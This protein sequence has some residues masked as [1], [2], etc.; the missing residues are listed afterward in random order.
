VASITVSQT[1]VV[2]VGASASHDNR[3]VLTTGDLSFISST[4]GL[5]N[6][7]DNDLIVQNGNVTNIRTELASGFNAGGGYWNGPAGILSSQAGS[8]TRF[9]TTLG[10]RQSDGSPFDGVGTTTSD[11]L[12]K[13]TYYGDANLD[14]VVNGADYQQID[15]GFGTHL[16]GWS[17]GDFN[18]D[19]VVDGSDYSLIDNT[20]NQI[21]ASGA[22]SLTMIAAPTNLIAGPADISSVPEPAMLGLVCIGA[23]GLSR[24]RR[25]L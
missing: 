1:G 5:L 16:T 21:T 18:Y 8:D 11:V 17:N 12:V 19:G 6:L 25:R 2:T 24:H 10:Y 9:L 20:F 22:G 4:G 14:G 13:Y 3:T 7:Q 23:M 15:M